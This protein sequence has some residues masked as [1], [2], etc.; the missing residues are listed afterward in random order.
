[1]GLFASL[2]KR[3]EK[4]R[5]RIALILALFV[6]ACVAIVGVLFYE[7]PYKVD[8]GARGQNPVRELGGFLSE[9]TEDANEFVA[10]L[11]NQ[12]LTQ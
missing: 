5:V 10:P 12:F 7:N 8:A 9:A 3:P 11:E 4:I 2:Q 6:V 1:M